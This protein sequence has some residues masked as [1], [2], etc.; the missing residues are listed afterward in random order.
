MKRIGY[1]SLAMAVLAL[2]LCASVA[3][4]DCTPPVG[5]YN[6]T[7]PG[8]T[9][10]PNGF[11]VKL[12]EWDNCPTSLDTY[13]ANYPNSVVIDEQHND[14]F[15]YA[16]KHLWKFSSDGGATPAQFENCSMYEFCSDVTITGDGGGE[17]GIEIS[18][19]WSLGDGQFMLNYGSGEIAVFG[20]R[21]PFY[22]FTAAYG[23]HYAKG[24]TVSMKMAYNPR[25]LNASFPGEVKY[26]LIVGGT[27]Y[28]S[29]WLNYD[30]G[31]TNPCEGDLHGLYGSLTPTTVGGYFQPYCGQGA[32][33]NVKAQFAGI[34]FN[35]IPTPAATTSWGKLK[36]IYR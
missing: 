4:A 35:P 28:D 9:P 33:W 32:D 14:C 36:S 11:F 20:G 29:G 2:G 25:N 16:D 10:T 18:P 26:I 8:T 1:H 21:L 34:C 7:C 27:I 22:S 13:V 30:E 5:T 17:A 6:I 31:N 24:T 12:N 3:A 19:W 15:G 23:L